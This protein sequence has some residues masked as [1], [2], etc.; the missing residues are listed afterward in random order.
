VSAEAMPEAAPPFSFCDTA[1]LGFLGSLPDRFCPFAMA[2]SIR[3]GHP[4]YYQFSV[5]S[6]CPTK[7]LIVSTANPICEGKDGVT[8]AVTVSSPACSPS[9]P[10]LCVC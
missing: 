4:E 9:F 8:R 3:D 6:V 2:A 10:A 7:E 5:T 1:F